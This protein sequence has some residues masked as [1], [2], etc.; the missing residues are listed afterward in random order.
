MVVDA[1]ITSRDPT[2][3]LLGTPKIGA[4]FE[5]R[6]NVVLEHLFKGVVVAP[7]LVRDRPF[8]STPKGFLFV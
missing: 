3:K 5:E 1:E 7:T 8:G 6:T 4:A 2:D